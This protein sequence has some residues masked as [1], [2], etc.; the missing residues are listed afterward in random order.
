MLARR[1]VHRFM[2]GLLVTLLVCLTVPVYAQDTI[3]IGESRNG[4]VT[5][6]SQPIFNLD[7]S[8]LDFTT[9]PVHYVTVSV[10]SLTSGFIPQFVV[11]GYGYPEGFYY[12]NEDDLSSISATLEVLDGEFSI[13]IGNAT[14]A[15]G[16][17][18]LSVTEAAT[19]PVTP[20]TLGVRVNSF[21]DNGVEIQRYTFDASPT[22]ELLVVIDKLTQYTPSYISGPTVTLFNTTV[23]W[24]FGRLGELVGGGALSIPPG[25]DTY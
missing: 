3:A 4:S 19:L 22:Q 21:V 11:S 16:N 2:I 10:T 24:P 13:G 25:T 14:D 1:I 6:T 23:G 17:F 12:D 18:T 7:T 15:T 20:I 8:T 5:S 9:Q